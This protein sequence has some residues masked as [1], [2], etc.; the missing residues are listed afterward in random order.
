MHRKM[1]IFMTYLRENMIKFF[2]REVQLRY[3]KKKNNEIFSYFRDMLSLK[4]ILYIYSSA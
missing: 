1:S 4:K 3:L 2:L